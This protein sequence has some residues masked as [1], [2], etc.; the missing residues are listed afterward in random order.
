MSTIS[1]PFNERQITQLTKAFHR[2][3]AESSSALAQWLNSAM[4]MSIDAVDQCPLETAIGV[5]GAAD[6]AVCMCLMEMQGT[7]TGHMLLAFDDVS[8]LAMSDLVMAREPGTASAWGEVE[9][10]SVLE[11]MNIAGSAYLNGIARDL[12]ER[13]KR[14]FELIP[15]PPQFL[16]DYAESILESAFMDQA[17]AASDVVFARARF[18]LSGQPL[19]WTFLLIPD[20]GSL[21]ILS[22]ILANLS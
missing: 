13:S 12:S 22:E 8:G 1:G 11:T 14:K 6:S 4:N 19:R 21:Q 5:L 2:G 17:I 20:P 10:S 16:R 18:D 15:S 7:L 3:A 9:I